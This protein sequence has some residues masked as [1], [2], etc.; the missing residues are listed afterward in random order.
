LDH[1]IESPGM[2]VVGTRPGAAPSASTRTVVPLAALLGP[3]AC[4]RRAFSAPPSSAA[5]SEG[6]HKM[7][8]R[9]GTLRVLGVL[10]MAAFAPIALLSA[11]DQNANP[12]SNAAARMI[13]TAEPHP[14][15][16]L[17]VIHPD[18]VLVY[19]KKQRRPVTAWTPFQGNN[20]GLQLYI[21]ID[22]S[23]AT[24][25]QTQLNDLRGFINQQPESTAIGLA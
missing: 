21:A 23:L 19:E 20:A 12:P 16:T 11:Q 5:P 24:G 6:R 4:S 10:V 25:V 13:V 3:A 8:N 18:D 9:A 14:G 2:A 1:R 7:K 15:A 17:P 22:D